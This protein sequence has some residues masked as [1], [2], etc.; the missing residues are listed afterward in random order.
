VVGPQVFG[1]TAVGVVLLCGTGDPRL[2]CSRGSARSAWA[3]R[4]GRGAR[5]NDTHRWA[6]RRRGRA[7]TSFGG[8]L[9]VLGTVVV[10][11]GEDLMS[12]L[13]EVLVDDLDAHSVGAVASLWSR[14]RRFR[15]ARRSPSS[16][17][18]VVIRPFPFLD[19]LRVGRSDAHVQPLVA[20]RRGQPGQYDREQVEQSEQGLRSAL[21]SGSDDSLIA[22]KSARPWGSRMRAARWRSIPAASVGLIAAMPST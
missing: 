18:G 7:S 22:S 9:V 10:F 12:G 17:R 20:D 14:Q 2:W 4:G 3:W 15:R 5:G 11:G 13:V 6:D 19:L 1:G 8:L 16:G 21:G